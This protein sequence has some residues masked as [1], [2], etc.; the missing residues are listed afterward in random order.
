M[1]HLKDNPRNKPELVNDTP[2]NVLARVQTRLGKM[3]SRQRQRLDIED[4]FAHGYDDATEVVATE[5]AAVERARRRAEVERVLKGDDGSSL[6]LEAVEVAHDGQMNIARLQARLEAMGLD[7]KIEGGIEAQVQAFAAAFADGPFGFTFDPNSL[8][9]PEAKVSALEDAL[10]GDAVN[11]VVV[12]AYPTREQVDAIAAKNNLDGETL[13]NLPVTVFLV[14]HFEGRGGKIADREN[15]LA[16]WGTLRWAA[17]GKLALPS[18]HGTLPVQPRLRD[19]LGLAQLS[20]TNTARDVAATTPLLQSVPAGKPNHI[21]VQGDGLTFEKLQAVGASILAPDERFALASLSKPGDTATYLSPNTWDWLSGVTSSC[22]VY[23]SS[24]SD[25]LGLNWDVPEYSYSGSR[26]RSVVRGTPV[27]QGLDSGLVVDM[28]ANEDT[29]RRLEIPGSWGVN[30]LRQWLVTEGLESRLEGGSL[31]HWIARAETAYADGALGFPLDRTKI[32]FEVTAEKLARL[33]VGIEAGSISGAVV[34][35]YPT[36]ADLAT[37]SGKPVRSAKELKRLRD[38][39]ITEFFAQHFGA[40]AGALYEKD[41]RIREWKTLR[42]AT[43]GGET[44]SVRMLRESEARG[45]APTEW[46]AMNGSLTQGYKDAHKAVYE[47]LPR[48]PRVSDRLGQARLVFTDVRT[49]VPQTTKLLTSNG[50]LSGVLQKDDLSFIRLVQ[51]AAPLIT[52]TEFLALASVL[53][54]PKVTG[55]Y[56]DPKTWELLDAIT[57]S[58]AANGDSNSVGL[59]LGWF[60]AEDSGEFSRARSAVR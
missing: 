12:T 22:A 34:E 3:Q 15:R 10:L 17:D 6:A 57:P 25:G 58:G 30:E 40:R 5:A 35:A 1:S 20:F 39:P 38:M 33:K 31:E 16:M 23:G 60:G 8:R 21:A 49:D 46:T 47:A 55:S 24:R 29:D 53:S 54:D 48:Q 27:F 13:L 18:A 14:R 2:E 28:K 26:A 52:P 43:D 7:V 45:L 4:A 19:V 41:D 50:T 37:P 51:E 44:I 36:L 11:G 32:R 9:F 42:W 59:R 56:I